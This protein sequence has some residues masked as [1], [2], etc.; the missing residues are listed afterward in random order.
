MKALASPL[1]PFKR[2]STVDNSQS[3]S[4]NILPPQS[5]ASISN[6]QLSLSPTQKNYNVPT[7]LIS[8]DDQL[9]D[10]YS[11]LLISFS[12]SINSDIL[13]SSQSSLSLSNSNFIPINTLKD[14]DP[15][16]FIEE[17][18]ELDNVKTLS[19]EEIISKQRGV[20]PASYLNSNNYFLFTDE[21]LLTNEVKN[22]LTSLNS[23]FNN[24]NLNQNNNCSLKINII[25]KNLSD[26]H[27]I[28]F[29]NERYYWLF[30]YAIKKY[31]TNPSYSSSINSFI[32]KNS[33][34]FING[35]CFFNTTNNA[36]NSGAR[37]LMNLIGKVS[38]LN[39]NNNP[40]KPSKFRINN[41]KIL[42]F[43]ASNSN[44]TF[45]SL[46]IEDILAITIDSDYSPVKELILESKVSLPR[47]GINNN[48]CT[49]EVLNY[50]LEILPPI[51]IKTDL[52][53]YNK[54]SYQTKNILPQYP[55]H[56]S[57]DLNQFDR[58][59]NDLYT[60]IPIN[61]KEFYETDSVSTSISSFKT[62]YHKFQMILMDLS[63]NGHVLLRDEFFV[64]DFFKETPPDNIFLNDVSTFNSQAINSNPFLKSSMNYSTK[65]TIKFR[66][67]IK[68]EIVIKQSNDF[69]KAVKLVIHNASELNSTSI[70]SAYCTVYLINSKGEKI[71]TNNP[72][73]RTD[74]VKSKNPN[75]NK[76][77]LLQDNNNNI[78]DISSILVIIRDS[79]SGIMKHKHLGQVMIN[80]EN[81]IDS[82]VNLTLP[83][84]PTYRMNSSLA[85]TS[86]LG[87]IQLTT[88]LVNV[89]HDD[90]LDE[91]AKRYSESRESLN[92]RSSF[93]QL[94]RKNT[95]NV[96]KLIQVPASSIESSNVIISNSLHRVSSL[97][98]WWPIKIFPIDESYNSTSLDSCNMDQIMAAGYILAS[99]DNLY[100]SVGRNNPLYSKL[101]EYEDGYL[102][103]QYSKV[104]SFYPLTPS[105]LYLNIEFNANSPRPTY[106]DVIVG[107][108]LSEELFKN[109]LIRKQFNNYLEKILILKKNINFISNLSYSNFNNNNSGSPP[110]S[111]STY[112]SNSSNHQTSLSSPRRKSIKNLFSFKENDKFDDEIGREKEEK[113]IIFS[114]IGNSRLIFNDLLSYHR[115]ILHDFNLL[116]NSIE[117]FNSSSFSTSNSPLTNS[118][119]ASSSPN[120]PYSSSGFL[121]T[122]CFI[123]NNY[124]KSIDILINLYLFNNL[125]T[126]YLKSQLNYLE[127]LYGNKYDIPEFSLLNIDRIVENNLKESQLMKNNA[128]NEDETNIIRLK[129]Y[130]L[131]SI[132][133]LKDF[134]FY[135]NID[136]NINN[137]KLEKNS[138]KENN[139][140]SNDIKE[141]EF[142]LNNHIQFLLNKNL[143][144]ITQTFTKL[145]NKNNFL[146]YKNN[147]YKFKILEFFLY[148]NENYFNEIQFLVNYYLN[149]SISS[150]LSTSPSM[151]STNILNSSLQ[152]IPYQV[153]N[154]LSD[155][156]CQ[157]LSKDMRTH[158][159]N[160][161]NYSSTNNSSVSL[162][163]EPEH[164][165]PIVS[166]LPVT[167]MIQINT[168]R[169]IIDPLFNF[170]MLIDDNFYS[171]KNLKS[172]DFKFNYYDISS[173][174]DLF[175]TSPSYYNNS[176]TLSSL[177]TS[178]LIP[179]NSSKVFS[180]I[181]IK[182]Y[183]MI[184]TDLWQLLND[185][186]QR[187]L[188]SKH[189]DA[190]SD[191]NEVEKYI[192]FLSSILN[193]S[194][195]ITND[196]LFQSFFFFPNT[197]LDEIQFSQ[198]D[199]KLFFDK[200]K[201][202]MSKINHQNKEMIDIVEYYEEYINN[203]SS[204]YNN[205]SNNT[206]FYLIKIIISFSYSVLFNWKENLKTSLEKQEKVS[207]NVKK[208]IYNFT[209]FSNNLSSKL[210]NNNYYKLLKLFCSILITRILLNFKESISSIPSS[211]QIELL[212]NDFKYIKEFFSHEIIKKKIIICDLDSSIEEKNFF[213]YENDIKNNLFNNNSSAIS[214]FYPSASESISAEVS[215]TIAPLPISLLVYESFITILS[216]S[217][218]STN[219]EHSLRFLV[220]RYSSA[221]GG[222]DFL[223]HILFDIIL[224]NRNQNFNTKEISTLLQ[225]I[226]MSEGYSENLIGVNDLAQL[227]CDVL[228]K[229][230]RKPID[231]A[232]E[233]DDKRDER[234]EDK[235]NYFSLFSSHSKK[236]SHNTS[237]P[238][239][240][241]FK[242]LR[243][244][245]SDLAPKTT[246][247][248][249]EDYATSILR[250]LGLDDK[251]LDD[252]DKNEKDNTLFRTSSFSVEDT[253]GIKKKDSK[254]NVFERK[255]ST[256]QLL[257]QI[258]SSTSFSSSGTSFPSP[259][260]PTPGISIT[261]NFSSSNILNNSAIYSL[262]IEE[263]A[264]KGIETTSMISKPNPYCSFVINNERVKT[265]VKS[266]KSAASWSSPLLLK[267][268]ISNLSNTYLKVDV[269]DK[270]PIRRKRLIGS[271]S[272]KLNGLDIGPKKSWYALQGGEQISSAEIHFSIRIS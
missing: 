198:D 25:T 151:S 72:E 227:N 64:G 7:S 95:T 207:H 130:L 164:S 122:S 124:V 156:F 89:I 113:D 256:N 172:D 241:A 5:P 162:P 250:E 244:K 230:F 111:P 63:E 49:S 263:I 37:P 67:K 228:W 56:I 243:E 127:N 265:T 32:E 235:H 262:I 21:K 157:G 40:E 100:I 78:T 20:Y 264:V 205:V 147:Y 55:L 191:S 28:L 99:L 219:F 190:S 224:P 258:A 159:T 267:V 158:L 61:I 239:S 259:L 185:E 166:H 123:N 222:D 213:M 134:L 249:N 98:T 210:N 46:N 139:S 92:H 196:Y 240:S 36:N 83:I 59:K 260:S 115:N 272:V 120:S 257:T 76:E 161:I 65:N 119:M 107:P 149:L 189:W 271:V 192:D 125:Y 77:F 66:N 24:K 23:S 79:S 105:V 197:E 247:Q 19:I 212:I 194:D 22:F 223:N 137:T 93:M 246:R 136:R 143:S 52:N 268:A 218:S 195:K 87:Q 15:Y 138:N 42:I 220:H 81:F 4:S 225:N 165:S 18:S 148:Y 180:S 150:S 140:K 94:N 221:N 215:S 104:L 85:E 97:H 201:S 204:S 38:L 90:F 6:I 82:E 91:N 237:A 242:M 133:N 102:I 84:E 27:S 155:M 236:N 116:Y 39:N 233:C 41:E 153:F 171:I 26:F 13:S 50:Q 232:S 163:W 131:L 173:L 106:I 266:S 75:F 226:Q 261:T 160:A 11:N 31:Y 135:Y 170:L 126:L 254:P 57:E 202:E 112:F 44:E 16:L 71:S 145:I 45:L 121:S 229:L 176:S 110:S 203:L 17:L 3:I 70:P 128:S 184:L 208:I 193:D 48:K 206:L 58:S 231:E 211:N 187:V 168:I 200:N 2:K 114:I 214:I 269:F 146:N 9:Y 35:N 118:S 177:F 234:K 255:S 80:I 144:I 251:F 34:N 175:R 88:Q 1:K 216:D 60:L 253:I 74:Q 248:K 183:H 238:N 188:R 53:L 154:D 182:K 10:N 217:T 169:K 108:C 69:N 86:Y 8:Y 178:H 245:A 43:N 132:D 270:E 30:L 186:Y 51:K 101:S 54:F 129:N 47:Q 142:I 14:K 117:D 33:N 12:K 29:N 209:S 179:A 174:Y 167:L 109:I 181:L 96:T 62:D 152:F 68:N 252:N 199:N 73:S 141:K 103:V